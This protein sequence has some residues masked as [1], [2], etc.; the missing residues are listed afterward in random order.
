LLLL[1]LLGETRER[2]GPAEPPHIAP[3]RLCATLFPFFPKESA[4]RVT[5]VEPPRSTDLETVREV[6]G[7]QDAE[8]THKWP[9]SSSSGVCAAVRATR[10][11]RPHV[12]ECKNFLHIQGKT[13]YNE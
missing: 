11:S 5:K 12:K 13:G 9:E 8:T 3:R 1:L 2:K 6:E 10:G 4:S 7:G